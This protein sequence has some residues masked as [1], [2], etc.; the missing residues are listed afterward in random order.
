MTTAMSPSLPTPSL[1][2]EA[3]TTP[4][5]IPP[6]DPGVLYLTGVVVNGSIV[7]TYQTQAALDIE[8]AYSSHWSHTPTSLV[9]QL[10]LG[11]DVVPTDENITW[12]GSDPIWVGQISLATIEAIVSGAKK[13]VKSSFTLYE[14]STSKRIDPAVIIRREV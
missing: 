13:V 12:V 9:I 7:L 14:S 5:I 8:L 3:T 4:S 6:V 10:P 2:P 1:S 11:W